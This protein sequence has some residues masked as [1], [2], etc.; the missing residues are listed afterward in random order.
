MPKKVELAIGVTV[1]QYRAWEKM[2]KKA[3]IANF[4]AQRLRERYIYSLRTEPK[5]GFAILAVS[6]LLVE[7]VQSFRFGW[8][9]T[10]K[11]GRPEKTFEAFFKENAR[12]PELNG[13]GKEIYTNIRCGILHQGET[14]SG[15]KIT[16]KQDFPLFTKKTL[17]INAVKFQNRLNGSIGDYARELKRSDW[18]SEI[19][20]RFRKKM[21]KVIEHCVK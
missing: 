4:I 13:Y 7:T 15:W 18:N 14:L 19:W 9:T 17:Q 10:R 12:F 3:E 11:K 2:Q 20:K 5:N 8:A 21:D 1:A 6:C 16:R